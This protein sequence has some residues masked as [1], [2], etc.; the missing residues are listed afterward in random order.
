MPLL[1]KADVTANV[2]RIETETAHKASHEFIAVRPVSHA[3]E[4]E[5]ETRKTV[6][7]FVFLVVQ[8][9]STLQPV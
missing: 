9:E 1:Q 2:I 3:I 6:V 4:I 5:A 7:Q 8:S